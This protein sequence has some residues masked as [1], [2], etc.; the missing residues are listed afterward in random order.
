M[1]ESTDNYFR[2]GSQNLLAGDFKTATEIFATIIQ[3]NPYDIRGWIGRADTALTWSY[4]LLEDY[5]E[6]AGKEFW[7]SEEELFSPVSQPLYPPEKQKWWELNERIMELQASAKKDYQKALEL[8]PTNLQARK[9]MSA[10][11]ELGLLT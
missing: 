10:L 5:Q 6:R 11:R 3:L 7:L 9:G 1:R 8:D 4:Q 2:K